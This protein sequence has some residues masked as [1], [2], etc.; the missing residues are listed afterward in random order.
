MLVLHAPNRRNK[1]SGS[2]LTFLVRADYGKIECSETDKDNGRCSADGSERFYQNGRDVLSEFAIDYERDRVNAPII[3]VC[4]IIA[5]H[6]A[7]VTVLTLRSKYAL[8]STI[9]K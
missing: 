6:T 5:Y 3:I 9:A 8:S 7:A 2:V 1:C 4:L